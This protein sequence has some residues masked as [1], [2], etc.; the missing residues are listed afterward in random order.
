MASPQKKYAAAEAGGC[1][2]RGRQA[3]LAWLV[4]LAHPPIGKD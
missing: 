3:G 1:F 2:F 4:Y